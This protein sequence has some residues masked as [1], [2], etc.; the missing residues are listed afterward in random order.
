MFSLFATLV[1]LGLAAI[2]PIGIA[3]MPILLLQHRPYQRC[4]IF[5]GGSFVS[6]IVMGLLIAGGLG[7]I[8]LHFTNSFNRIVPSLEA[9]AGGLLLIIAAVVFWQKRAGRL[10]YQPSPYITERL[11]LNN[12][13]LFVIGA[14]L[15]AIQSIADVVFVVAMI[16]IGKL[17]LSFITL[18]AAVTTYALAAIIL[19]ITVVTAYRLTPPTRRIKTLTT[20]R[21]WLKDYINQLIIAVSLILGIIL[22]I[23]AY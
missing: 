23:V 19:Q 11:Q 14:G 6:L 13:H 16:R 2:D 20:I 10:Q 9:T 12:W 15:V 8:I 18:L 4:L 7:E 5:L 1:V 22:L 17:N 3:I 21:Q